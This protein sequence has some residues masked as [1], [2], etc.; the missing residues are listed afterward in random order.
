MMTE[1]G[2]SRSTI[3]FKIGIVAQINL[4]PKL[5]NSSLS[6]YFLK[7]HMKVIKEICKENSS[8]FK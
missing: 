8:K 3:S 1:F 4:Y 7:K 5:K 2:G 6:L